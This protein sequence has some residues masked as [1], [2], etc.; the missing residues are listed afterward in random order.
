[1]KRKARRWWNTGVHVKD[2]TAGEGIDD[3][4]AR[5]QRVDNENAAQQPCVNHTNASTR[6]RGCVMGEAPETKPHT[7][8]SGNC[9]G[10]LCAKPCLWHAVVSDR[11]SALRLVSSDHLNER[12]ERFAEASRKS[13]LIRSRPMAAERLDQPLDGL[14]SF[15]RHGPFDSMGSS[16]AAAHNPTAQWVEAATGDVLRTPEWQRLMDELFAKVQQHLSDTGI[17]VRGV[18]HHHAV[19]LVSCSDALAPL[20]SPVLLR[21][22]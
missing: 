20:L 18:L 13:V 2:R 16:R 14:A 1:M 12:F 9:L 11:S 15:G 19:S 3:N 22:Q 4:S 5:D 8:A 6:F 21:S 17:E 7:R 10:C